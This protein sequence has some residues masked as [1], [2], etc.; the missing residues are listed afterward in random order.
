M[1]T[2]IYTSIYSNLWG[3]EFGGRPSREL[4]YKYSLLSIL[5]L[6]P[7]K[8]ICFTSEEELGE[9][10]SWFYEINKISEDKLEF[11]VFDLTESRF[12]N[13]IRN[14]KNLSE[15][16]TSDRCYEIQYNKFFWL[17]NITNIE[18]YEKIYW[19]DAGLSHGG[20]FPEEYSYGQGFQKHFSFTVFNE[21]YLNYLNTITKDKIVI[22]SKN[23]S[24]RFYWSSSIP[25]KYYDSYNNSEHIIGGFFGGNVSLMVEFKNQFEK[26][27]F[28]LLTN[29]S[30]LYHEELIMSFMYFNNPVLFTPL[31]FDDWY[32]RNNPETNSLIIKYFYEIFK[33]KSSS[34]I[35]IATSC[36]EINGGSHYV[37]KTKNLIES[38]LKYTK[39]DL[40]IL[41]NQMKQFEEI[42]NYRVKFFNYYDNFN[43][44]LTS[45]NFFNMHLKRLPIKLSLNL[46]YEIIFYNDCDCFITGWDN[47]SFIEKCNE[48]FDV[49][50]VSHANPQLGGLRSIYK[51]FQDKIDIEFNELYYD[52]LD[53]APNPA[54]TRVI[55][56]KNEKLIKFLHFWDLVSYKNNDYFTYHD[57]VYFGTSAI[58]SGMKMIG[59]TPFDEFT[60]YCRI[61]HDGGELDYFGIKI[62]E[63]TVDMEQ[64]HTEIESYVHGSFNYKGLS[65]LQ[66]RNIND[67]FKKLLETTKPK[68]IIE[69][70]TEF[71]G[72]TLLLQD[73]V[74]EL[75]L[76]T[77]IRTYDIKDPVF[78]L[79]HPELKD[80]VEIIKKD[81]FLYNPFRLSENS[82]KELKEFMS[83]DGVNIILCDG[84]DKKNEFN[85]LSK[86]L[87]DGD[88][89]MLHD[90]ITDEHEFQEKF[91]NKIWNWHESKFSDIEISVKENNLEPF[92]PDD[93][94]QVVW[95]SFIKKRNEG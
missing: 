26:I 61:S 28:S 68:K 55:F 67:K 49:A 4:H 77:I 51:H 47:D 37:E 56:K 2:L 5:K 54:E 66:H 10:K 19:F 6:N 89:I 76:D 31:K 3:T 9:L 1:K 72:L 53:N 58:Y 91:L 8:L 73:I 78:L 74:H 82:T 22:V 57:G 15:I 40:V 46:G 80:N 90:Y 13:E 95:G 59:I 11:I 14:L 87:N 48:D 12:F 86:I 41:T 38:Y 44:P 84:G 42:K 88:I 18:D 62:I 60:K 81:L 21:D 45:A 27:L 39:Y 50:F 20:L 17:E 25:T 43:E 94:L 29:E 16:I 30:E 85:A 71:G 63:N 36:I 23:N 83:D 52:E 34:K 64:N 7:D 79:S 65:M 75:N 35:C 32:N 33:I 92:M 69:I 24:G 93:F 70:G